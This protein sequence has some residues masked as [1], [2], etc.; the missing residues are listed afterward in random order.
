MLVGLGDLSLPVAQPARERKSRHRCVFGSMDRGSG[1]HEGKHA[2][3]SQ[4]DM[5]GVMPSCLLGRVLVIVLV[6]AAT[7]GLEADLVSR[8]RFDGDLLDS[9]P[10]G[11]L[12]TEELTRFASTSCKS[13]WRCLSCREPFDHFKDH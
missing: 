4:T 5:G 2:S 9:G 11:N 12:D 13:L 1:R 3:G 8:W 6:I 10:G 7:P